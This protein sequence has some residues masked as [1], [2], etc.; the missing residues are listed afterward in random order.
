MASLTI[1]EFREQLRRNF[2]IY[3]NPG[4]ASALANCFDVNDRGD[5]DT[6]KFLEYFFRLK[7]SE[8]DRHFERQARATREILKMERERLRVVNERFMKLAEAKLTPAT[9]EDKRSVLK[10]FRAAAVFYK[11]NNFVDEI[12]KAFESEDLSPTAFKGLVQR[13]FEIT[14]SPGELD[15]AVALFDDNGDGAISCVE[16]KTTF[17]ELAMIE[18]SRMLRLKVYKEERARRET[19]EREQ[20]RA[21]KFLE[22]VRTRVEWPILP[23][24]EDDDDI[25]SFASGS[26]LTAGQLGADRGDGD[27]QSIGSWSAGGGGSSSNRAGGDG[28]KSSSS[29]RKSRRPTMAEILGGDPA[30]ASLASTTSSLAIKF[31]K[32]SQETKVRESETFILYECV[33]Q[34]NCLGFEIL[35]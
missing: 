30:V 27:D 26:V 21:E 13:V 31:P 32:A 18:R 2:E 23:T 20:A 16:F 28:N 9:E 15:A 14:L 12:Q 8:I 3:L 24:A 4:E 35:C 25:H 29:S 33:A 11:K 34:H 10:K 22:S 5:V 7:R 19:L 1:V 17:F 6:S